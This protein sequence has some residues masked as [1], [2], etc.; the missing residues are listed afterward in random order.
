MPRQCKDSIAVLGIDIGKNTFRL[1]GLNKRGAIIVRLK[2]SRTQ[3]EAKLAN[4]R[5]ASSAYLRPVPLCTH[6]VPLCLIGA[7][8]IDAAYRQMGVLLRRLHAIPM[9]A[10][11]FI[12]ADDGLLP[13]RNASRSRV[14]WRNS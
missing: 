3:L 9:S 6:D 1:V 4:L 14:V 2:Q 12:V 5:P 10:Y 11:G 13:G 8:G 7:P